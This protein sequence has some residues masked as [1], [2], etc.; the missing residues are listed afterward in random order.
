MPAFPTAYFGSIAYFKELVKHSEV[1]IEAHEHFPKQT[2]RNRC[3]I[4][5]GDGITSLSIP[6]KRP[7]G[8]KTFTK[9]ILLSDQENWRARHWRSIMSGYQ[10]APYFD[11]YGVEVK[12]LLFTNE[13]NLLTFNLNITRRI[14]DW[15]D[16]ETE[17][18]VTDSFSPVIEHDPR[19]YLINKNA[20]Q[21]NKPCPYI[22]V[23][24]GDMHYQESL[25]I[26]DAVFCEG[27]LARNLLLK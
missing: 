11:Y 26:L 2:Y 1:V 17:I 12:E 23:F 7:N 25:S 18:H 19:L 20:Y 6:V 24:P 27:P 21:E 8:T 22:Q 9:D 4:L 3:D 16:I 15:L 10:A 14:L 13:S 5:G